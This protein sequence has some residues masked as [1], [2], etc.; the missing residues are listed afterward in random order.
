MKSEMIDGATDSLSPK[1]SSLD[2]QSVLEG[3]NIRDGKTGSGI[4]VET[5]ENGVVSV[6]CQ[7]SCL[8]RGSGSKGQDVGLLKLGNEKE[9]GPLTPCMDREMVEFLSSSDHTE[10][11]DAVPGCQTPT[12]SIFDPFAPG[13][14]DLMLAPKKKMR[15]ESKIPL[16][17][18]LDFDSCDD[19]LE[20]VEANAFEDAAQED[21]LFEL[22]FKSFFELIV[23]SQA[24]EI[25]A[26]RLRVESN[27]SEGFGTPTYLSFL[28]GIAETCP[29]APMRLHASKA[30]R[31]SPDICRKLDFG[32]NLN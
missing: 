20:N 8:E 14:E 2:K 17:R 32:A 19:S 28:A 29:D 10:L 25:S 22:I 9:F 11:Q 23:S 13:P 3:N 31:L 7:A 26:E 1:V 6:S 16:R 27:A 21:R 18:Q 5:E 4:K 30:R 12:E 24:N 15:R